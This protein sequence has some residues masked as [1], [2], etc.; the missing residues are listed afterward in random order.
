MS[1]AL[2]YSTQNEADVISG[3]MAS[4]LAFYDSSEI[5]PDPE[6]IKKRNEINMLFPNRYR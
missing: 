6:L 5:L 4:A 3:A 2:V 1:E